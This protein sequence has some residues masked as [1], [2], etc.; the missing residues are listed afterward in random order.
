MQGV[1]VSGIGFSIQLWAVGK[2]GPVFVSA[3]LPVQTLLVAVM[4]SL[5][6]GEKFYLG[7]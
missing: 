5:A 3:Y 2:A 6:L 7:G 1:V 4:A